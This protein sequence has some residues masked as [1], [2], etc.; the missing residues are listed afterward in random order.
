MLC[1]RIKVFFY[2]QRNR[3][4]DLSMSILYLAIALYCGIS[5]LATLMVYAACVMA[6]RA[7]RVQIAEDQPRAEVASSMVLR[8]QP[9]VGR[10]QS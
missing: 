8:P 4:K 10:R 5:L 2:Y 6:G 7:D 9:V 3:V 1:L